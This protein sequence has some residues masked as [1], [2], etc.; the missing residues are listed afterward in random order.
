[1]F[2]DL[3]SH[4]KTLYPGKNFIGLHEP[5]FKGNEKKYTTDCIDSTF[6]SSVGQYVNRFEQSIVDYTR[7]PYAVACVNGTAA[8]HMALILCDVE[9]DDEVLTQ[10]LTFVATANAISYCKAVPVFLDSDPD[11]LGMS[12]QSLQFFLEEFAELRD[13][14]FCYNKKTNRRIKACVPMHVFGH[15]VDIELIQLL[16]EKYK[17]KLIEDSAES[18]GSF[19]K[20]KHTGAFSDVS[21]LS[22][23]GNKTVTTGGGG[24]LI[25]KHEAL[26]KKAKHLTTTAKI[27]HAWE[28]YHDQIGYNYRLPNI[29]S[30]LGLA[31]MEY[32]PEILSNKKQTALSYKEFCQNK[33]YR[34]VDQP[35]DSESNFWLNSLLLESKKQRDDFLEI[36]NKN[37]VMT[38][39]VW[40]LM[41]ELQQFKQ[42]QSV[43]LKNAEYIRDRLVNL[44]SSYRSHL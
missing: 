29:N 18:L 41:P 31:Q 20:N 2:N 17:I 40:A 1:M 35:K 25:F 23:N 34:F 21:V 8:L 5:I 15:P 27:P 37:G 13:D 36:T 43:D 33:D 38:R 42:T 14:G 19:Y 22:F 39:P 3:I 30:A 32:L 12:V 6:V 7:I 4:V 44:P 11:R 9:Q 16:C 28:F 10:A 24:M 26:A